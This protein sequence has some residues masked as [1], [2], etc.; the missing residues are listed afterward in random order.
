MFELHISVPCGQ[1]IGSAM[2]LNCSSSKSGGD[3]SVNL[4][5]NL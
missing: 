1:S 5:V 2:F 3:Q 4:A